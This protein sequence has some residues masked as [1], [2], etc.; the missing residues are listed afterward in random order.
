MV[1]SFPCSKS[2]S[3]L[4]GPHMS[5]IF[6][7]STASVFLIGKG[8]PL[9]LP[10]STALESLNVKFDHSAGNKCLLSVTQHCAIISIVQSSIFCV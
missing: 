2:C 7:P 1:S 4:R 10:F 6:H 8:I 3:G 5:Q 9:Y